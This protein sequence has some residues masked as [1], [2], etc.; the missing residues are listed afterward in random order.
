MLESSN[1]ILR[2]WTRECFNKK[3]IPNRSISAVVKEY[4][5]LLVLPP[6]ISERL[7]KDVVGG[8]DTKKSRAYPLILKRYK[9]VGVEM[10]K[11]QT[12]PMHLLFL[13]LKKSMMSKTLII[14]NPMVKVQ[15]EFWKVLTGLMQ[16][17][18]SAV[19][20]ISVSWCMS[21]AFFGA[22]KIT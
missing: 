6:P 7:G 18:Q 21:M 1:E 14:V 2:K 5:K 10:K 16:L 3:N 9:E 4:L 13:G 22:M 12:M 8:I 19:N 20:S 17:T 15:N 11:C